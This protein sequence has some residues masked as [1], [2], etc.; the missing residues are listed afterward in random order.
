VRQIEV[1]IEVKISQ[2]TSVSAGGN[3][4]FH[5]KADSLMMPVAD[6]ESQLLN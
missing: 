1:E 5:P 4:T 6:Y 3:L 2:E